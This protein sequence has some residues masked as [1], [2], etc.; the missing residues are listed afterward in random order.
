MRLQEMKQSVLNLNVHP[1]KL[2][3]GESGHG[4]SRYDVVRYPIFDKVNERMQSLFWRPQEIDVSQEKRSFNSMTD[5]EQFVFASNL[6]RQILLDS[7]QGR[8][9]ALVFLPHCTDPSLENC[10]LTWSY[11]ETIHSQS[12]THIIRSVFSDPKIV[13]DSM[14]EIIQIA[15]CANDITKAYDAMV[16][17]PNKEN[18]YLS[19]IAANALEAIRFYVSF[20]CT[21]SFAERALVEGSSKIVKLIARDENVHLSLVQHIL[22]IL[23]QDDPE[24]IQIIGDNQEKARK[25]FQSAAEQEKEW[26]EYLF[27]DGSI[28][29]LNVEILSKYIDFLTSKRMKAIGLV[30]NAPKLEHPIPWIEKHLTSSNAQVAPQEVELSS[31]LSG[32]VVNNISDIDFSQMWDM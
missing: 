9:P 19:L 2:F 16:N 26:A 27:T 6:K 31:Y 24:F 14:P 22:K 21:F 17:T 12:Y 3:F 18:L 8:A 23:P 15:D 29:G 1:D 7:I 30:N 32:S 13:I 28:L 25:I 4:I 11:F 5:I 20:A 10:L